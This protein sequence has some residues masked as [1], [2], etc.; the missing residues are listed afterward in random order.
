MRLSQEHKRLLDVAIPDA[1]IVDLQLDLECQLGG[2]DPLLEVLEDHV[3]LS[4]LLVR[5][6]EAQESVWQVLFDFNGLQHGLRCLLHV[7]LL[8]KQVSQKQV[9]VSQFLE[10]LHFVK[11]P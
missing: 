6:Y 1:G 4:K 8:P 10:S 3:V 11:F 2:L 7:R 9:G 5:F